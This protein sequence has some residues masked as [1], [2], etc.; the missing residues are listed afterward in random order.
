MPLVSQETNNSE[1]LWFI[2]FME[3]CVI[4]QI[5]RDFGTPLHLENL[6]SLSLLVKLLKC[7]S[8]HGFLSLFLL[9]FFFRTKRGGA[10]FIANRIL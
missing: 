1:F 8:I 5:R 6:I 3:A 9:L 10:K 7:L 2:I 4:T